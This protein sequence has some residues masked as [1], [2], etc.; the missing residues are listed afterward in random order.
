MCCTFGDQTDVEWWQKYNLE[1]RVIIDDHGSL[2]LGGLVGTIDERY[3]SLD[4]LSTRNAR[5]R[6][7]KLLEED[8]KIAK[9]PE[10]IVHSVKVSERSKAP[11]EFLIKKQWFIR[12]M[13]LKDKLH[14]QTDRIEWKPDWMRTRLHN[15]IDGLAMD[16][17]ISRQRFFGVPI[18][19][20]YSRRKGEEG[21][22]IAPNID[23]LPVD[24]MVDLPDGYRRDEIIAESDILDTWATS[25]ITPQLTI[26]GIDANLNLDAKRYS[27]LKIPFDLRA[28]GHDII[29]TWAFYTVLRSYYH[30]GLVPWKNIMINGW[31]LASD[32]AKMSKSLGNVIDPV[33]IFDQFGSDALRYWTA[34]S[35][36]G[37][38]TSYQESIV[39]N[40][41]K[42]IIKLFNGA[43]FIEIHSGNLAGKAK[44]VENGPE[45]SIIFESMD[46][47]LLDGM[48]VL[49]QGY[50]RAFG[51]Y[52]YS[53]ALELLESFFWNH[54]CDNYLETVKIRCYG[55]QSSRYEGKSLS[56]KEQNRILKSQ[57]S[58]LETI[59]YV[60]GNLL[61]LFAPFIPVVC[62]E[63]YSCLFE[64]EFREKK[65]IHSRGNY[66]RIANITVDENIRV[67]GQT[68][69]QIVAD[70]RKHKS[71]RNVSLKEKLGKL[72]IYSPTD[73]EVAREDIENVC[74]ASDIT[75]IA[76]RK[77]RIVF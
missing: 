57:Q 24:P 40:G 62:E 58:A 54:F 67:T 61:R 74:N 68:I 45:N 65:S 75:L 31:C 32:G 52:E 4:G 55:L 63:I 17:C 77:Y 73:L 8:R 6:I 64:E 1:T 69:L 36:L 47:W 22:V 14:E 19:L 26:R 5:E 18:P 51:D 59:Y 30:G 50:D 3:L 53:R 76:D 46:L 43:K 9:N 7:L 34:K 48:N 71:E 10:K 44:D 70:V 49:I 39:R 16:W 56:E 27:T 25:S 60:Y 15:W 66:A 20:W 21:R 41:Q 37:M 72:T 12:T 35:S 23:Q 13:D 28:Q 42:L 33:K 38:D 11:I 2:R 29:R